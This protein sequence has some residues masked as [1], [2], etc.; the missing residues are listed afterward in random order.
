MGGISDEQVE[1]A[2]VHRLKAM[3]DDPP[4]TEFNVTQAFAHFTAILLWTTRRIRVAH[5][6]GPADHAAQRAFQNL[7]RQMIFDP[8]WSLSR[9]PPNLD[10]ADVLGDRGEVNADFAV[11]TVCDFSVWL[12]NALAHGDGRSIRPIHKQSRSTGREYLVGFV[13]AENRGPGRTLH[14]YHQDMIR[15]GRELANN[16]CQELSQGVEYFEEDA[17]ALVVEAAE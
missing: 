3:L 2:I 12:R 13:L 5:A 9:Q 15:I 16:F 8:P 14:L 4:K 7:Q 10:N 6:V 1:W 11:T 17:R